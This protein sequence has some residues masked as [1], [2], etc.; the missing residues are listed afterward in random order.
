MLRRRQ[1]AV[2]DV[3][4]PLALLAEEVEKPRPAGQ[5]DSGPIDLRRN[6]LESLQ[7]ILEPCKLKSTK[8]GNDWYFL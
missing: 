2:V 8:C 6:G 4:P 3:L 1:V 7:L 5:E